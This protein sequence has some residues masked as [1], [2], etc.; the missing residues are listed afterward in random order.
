MCYLTSEFY[1]LLGVFSHAPGSMPYAIPNSHSP[2][3][4]PER[5]TMAG[6]RNPKLDFVPG[7]MGLT[8]GEQR[9]FIIVQI[10][11]LRKLESVR[12]C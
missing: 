4:S 12:L 10:Q 9:V 6:R 5:L 11:G 2:P 7:E 1:L 3:A 8:Q